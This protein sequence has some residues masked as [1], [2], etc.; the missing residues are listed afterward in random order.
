MLPEQAA[1]ITDKSTIYERRFQAGQR[2]YLRSLITDELIE[3]H[4]KSPTGLH[5][6]ALE[7]VLLY[8]RKA[9]LAGKYAVYCTKPFES[10]RIVALSGMPGVP[11]RVVD[12]RTYDSI[13]EAYHAVFL[14]RIND[15]KAH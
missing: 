11:P 2:D 13:D 15:L 3:E 8:F 10:Y 1:E 6:E 7:R 12:D 5:S 4:R 9:E 14:R